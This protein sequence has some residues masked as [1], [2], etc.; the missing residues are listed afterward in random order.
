MRNG[1]RVSSV[2]YNG[3]VGRGISQLFDK[4]FL[5][6]IVG[7]WKAEGSNEA[8]TNVQRAQ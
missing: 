5:Q 3:G 8:S 4:G 7:Y 2:I 6:R 1:A